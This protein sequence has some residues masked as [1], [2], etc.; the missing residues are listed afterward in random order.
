MVRIKINSVPID[1][2]HHPY[3]AQI[4]TMT[5]IISALHGNTTAVIESPTGTGK[6]LSIL[7]STLAWSEYMRRNMPLHPAKKTSTGDVPPSSEEKQESIRIYIC[8]RTH[9]QLDQLVEQLRKTR[10][11]PRI[12]ILA[13]RAQYCINPTLRDVADKNNGCAELVRT[14]GCIYFNGKD[15]LSKRIAIYDIE[16]LKKEGK[17]CSGCPYYAS[18]IMADKSEVIFAPYNYLIDSNIRSNMSINLENSIIIIDEAHNIEDVCR[19]AGSVELTSRL[20]EIIQNDILGVIKKGGANIAEVREDLICILGVMRSIKEYAEKNS[21]FDRKNFD[22]HIKIKKGKQISQELAAMGL[23][24]NKIMQ[25]KN[26]IFSVGKNELCKE[27]INASIMHVLEGFINTICMA[28]GSNAD[29]Y[30]YALQKKTLGENKHN[31]KPEFTLSFWLLD[32]ALVFQPLVKEARAIILLSGTLTPFTGLSS[33]LGHKFA[34]LIEAP[35]VTNSE[36][37]FVASLSRGHLGGDLL[38]TYNISETF[39]YLDQISKIIM[40]V[41]ATVTQKGGVLVFVPSY[42]FLENIKRRLDILKPKNMFCEPKTA[43]MNEFEKVL[44]KYKKCISMKQG[45]VLLCVYRGK[46]SEGVDF[47]DAHARVVIAVGIPFPS[48]RDVQ[49]ELKREFND[50]FKNRGGRVWYE[51]QAYRAVNQALGRCIRHKDDWGAIFLLDSRY[52]DKRTID[53]MPK[54]VRENHKNY[55]EFES[56]ETEFKNFINKMK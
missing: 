47:K 1:I 11:Q 12:S 52:K 13:S 33:E 30:A 3:E 19:S 43:Q 42:S 56:C 40:Q 16:E 53:A 25:L 24:P 15:K 54:W 32:P 10:Y 49:V 28:S 18:R 37:V 45:A 39:V 46:A 51:T 21:D 48:F 17:K 55:D 7:C 9:K 34:H 29:S 50:K 6:S 26:S 8:S 5:A 35:H 2:P 14:G 38:G 23:E 27:L 44:N 36:H 41:Y 31:I 20:I 22:A 4:A